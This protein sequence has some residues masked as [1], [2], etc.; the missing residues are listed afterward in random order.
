MSKD[1]MPKPCQHCPFRTDVRPFLT[2]ERAEEIAYS[3]QNPYNTF[4]CHKTTECVEDDDGNSDMA[5]TENSKQCAGFLTLQA[6]ESRRTM[7]EGF[8]PSF[9]TCYNS[10]SEMV[11]AYEEENS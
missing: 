11:D 9:D 10:A 2:T 1:Y 3:A 7:P 4:P 5:E 8:E 6:N